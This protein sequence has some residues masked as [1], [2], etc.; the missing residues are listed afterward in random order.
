[1][2]CALSDLTDVFLWLF[3]ANSLDV[4]FPAGTVVLPAGDILPEVKVLLTENALPRRLPAPQL[5]DH[6]L[7]LLLL[8]PEGPHLLTHSP[9]AAQ[10]TVLFYYPLHARAQLPQQALLGAS[11]VLFRQLSQRL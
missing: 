4:L 2:P 10:P 9:P 11:I 7:Q 6:R 3:D 8:L 1:M 5:V